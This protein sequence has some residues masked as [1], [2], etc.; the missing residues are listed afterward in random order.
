MTSSFT[1]ALAIKRT[2]LLAH[3]V[4]IV[5][6][7]VITLGAGALVT[8]SRG[9]DA[10]VRY[11]GSPVGR[12][13]APVIGIAATR[14]GNGYWL[15]SADG[16][17][18]AYGDARYYGSMAGRPLNQPIVGMAATR[19][20]RGYWL[21]AR[22]GGIFSFGDARFY[23]STG[24]MQLNQPIVGMAATRAGRGYWLVAGD[25]GIFSFG[26]ARFYGSTGAIRLAKPVVS[27]AATPGGRG[28]WMVASDGGIFSFG[29]AR[30]YGSTG[31]LRIPAPVTGMTPSRTGGYWLVGADG[32]V[33]AFGAARTTGATLRVRVFA[34][35][36]I[37][38]PP[39]GGFWFATL[40]GRVYSG[41]PD[42]RLIP[43][44]TPAARP[45][46]PAPSPSPSAP[47]AIARDLANRIN[48]ER[49]ARG[50]APLAYD[51]TLSAL[52]QSWSQTMASQARMYH[53]NLSALFANP[54][55]G[56]RYRTI[57][58]NIYNGWGSWNTSGAA[59]VSFMNSAPHR[60]TILMPELT[61]V[62]IG[63]TCVNGRLWIAQE[64]GVSI[65][66]PLPPAPATPP[67]D[68]IAAPSLG[69]PGC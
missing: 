14:T 20:G 67:V 29:D 56:S 13:R 32:T 47:S 2:R 43:D 69:G 45:P 16:G 57:R 28:Y 34:A 10:I 51:P 7:C 48:I 33:Y 49:R 65:S 24:A 62:G 17:V 55:Y 44:P 27:M 66:R 41:T 37:S 18:F 21:V 68:P 1:R 46:A 22:D 50:L 8:G 26:D 40:D 54:T 64:F 38:A 42:G 25:G 6:L 15:T 31:G 52:A 11:Y 3:R 63:A 23:G 35:M 59:H 60:A 30:F 4:P 53:Q 12:L 19:S 5:V 58:E 61:S 39:T 36:A 9:A